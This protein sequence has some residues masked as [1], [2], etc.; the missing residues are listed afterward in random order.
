ML[1]QPLFLLYLSCFA[2]LCLLFDPLIFFLGPN[3]KNAKR[4][5]CFCVPLL[6]NELIIQKQ[7][8]ELLLHTQSFVRLHTPFFHFVR[9][10]S[11]CFLFSY[12]TSL[13]PYQ[14]T[15]PSQAK[16]SRD[17]SCQFSSI[18]EQGNGTQQGLISRH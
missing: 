4:P 17:R 1:T 12:N 15:K 7:F 13:T 5:F 10:R 6:R 11:T 14:S 8:D 9:V 3:C 2:L 16:P 18:Q